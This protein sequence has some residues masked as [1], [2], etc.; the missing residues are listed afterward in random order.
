MFLLLKT[1]RIFFVSVNPFFSSEIALFIVKERERTVCSIKKK[2]N[3]AL[4]KTKEFEKVFNVTIM[5]TSKRKRIDKNMMRAKVVKTAGIAFSQVGVK[6]VRMD[7]VASSLAISKRTLY[8]LFSDKEE[9]LVEVVNIRRNEVKAYMCKVVSEA[10][11]VLQVIIGFYEMIIEDI[12]N[13]NRNFFEDIK[14]Y[15]KVVAF[16]NKSR[17][18]NIESA[19]EFYQKGVEQGIFRADVN[20]RIVQEMISGQMDMLMKSLPMYSLE[21]I[22]ETLV[23]MHLRGISTEK[24]LKIVNDFL[25][26]LKREHKSN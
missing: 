12:R 23:F 2:S 19:I 11:N 3:F 18:E 26:R 9:L 5:D 4:P 25:S 1:I 21:E 17:E 14:K 20:Y 22:F 15:P 16:L 24:G 8:E 6:N 13:T 10:E 7:D